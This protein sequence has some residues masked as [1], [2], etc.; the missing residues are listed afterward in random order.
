MLDERKN[1]A[2]VIACPGIYMYFPFVCAPLDTGRRRRLRVL[3][4][5]RESARSVEEKKA[6]TRE[7][8]TREV[9]E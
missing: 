4:G 1:L 2:G 6:E 5:K 3:G 7:E 8:N 9:E